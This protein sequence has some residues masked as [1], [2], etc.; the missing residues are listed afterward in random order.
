MKATSGRIILSGKPPAA[1]PGN[2][3]ETE[4]SIKAASGLI[5]L[6]GK[7]LTQKINVDLMFGKR[8]RRWPNIKSTLI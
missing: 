8:R 5:I 3:G 1:W 2:S 7:G 4:G 6:S